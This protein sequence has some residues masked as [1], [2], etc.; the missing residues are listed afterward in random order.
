VHGSIAADDDQQLRALVRS[1]PR[2][3]RQLARGT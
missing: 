1:A 3:L 2:Q